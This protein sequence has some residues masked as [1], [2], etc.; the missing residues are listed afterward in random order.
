MN[1][2]KPPPLRNATTRS[3]CY[4]SEHRWSEAQEAVREQA[5]DGGVH[6]MALIGLALGLS[7]HKEEALEI[8]SRITTISQANPAYYELAIVSYGV[9]NIDDTFA[10]LDRSHSTGAHFYEL[11]GP[12]F[13]SLRRD[14]RFKGLTSPRGTSLASRK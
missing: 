11:L 5:A 2:M 13:D 12:V 4:D 14:P 10:N 6:A 8:R 1:A 9:G 3:L 7:G